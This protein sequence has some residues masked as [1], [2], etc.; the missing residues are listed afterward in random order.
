MLEKLLSSNS[1]VSKFLDSLNGKEHVTVY[2]LDLDARMLIL[3]ESD[4]RFLYITH[5]ITSCNKVAELCKKVGYNTGVLLPFDYNFSTF[6]NKICTSNL[7][8]LLSF[9]QG[10][11][12]CIIMPA[13][14]LFNKYPNLANNILRLEVGNSYNREELIDSLLSNGYMRVDGISDV[15]DFCIKGEILDI[16]VEQ[17]KCAR[18]TFFDDEIEKIYYYDKDTFAT[19]NS[20]DT[21]IVSN[22]SFSS[23][24][25]CDI[26]SLLK[27]LAQLADKIDD[28]GQI[29]EYEKLVSNINLLQVSKTKDITYLYPYNKK[30]CNS[31]FDILPKDTVICFDD[32]KQTFDTLVASEKEMLLD[33]KENIKLALA[34]PKHQKA[35]W[36]IDELKNKWQGYL[37][38]AFGIITS[39]NKLFDSTKVF[40]IKT[41]KIISYINNRKALGIDAKRYIDSGYTVII[42]AGSKEY[43]KRVC[44]EISRERIDCDMV[45]NASLISSNKVNVLSK[46]LP[47]SIML[48]VDKIIVIGTNMLLADKKSTIQNDEIIV[49]LPKIGDYVVHE[50]YGIGKYIDSVVLEYNNASREYFV[51]EYKGGD[52]LYLPCEYMDKISKY[53]GD[54]PKE[55]K[56]GSGDFLKAKESVKRSLKELAFD[57]KELY[58]KRLDSRGIVVPRDSDIENEISKT[59]E[60]TTTPDQENAIVDVYNDLA[61]GKIMDR[62][63][64]GD[65]GYGKTEV[66]IRA[67]YKMVLA[68][69]QVMFL[70]PT[71]ILSM[72]H[73]NTCNARLKEYGITVGVLNRFVSDQKR[74]EIIR[75]FLDGKI[76]VLCGTH[77]LLSKDVVAHKL[78][79]LVLDEEQKFGV[80]DKEKIKNIRSNIHV[81]TLSATPI[82]RTLNMSLVGIRDISIINTPPT[83]RLNV[84]TNVVGYSDELLKNAIHRELARG[85]QVLIVNNS[86][87]KIYAFAQKVKGLIGDDSVT[88]GVAHGQMEEHELS[89]EIFKLYNG[90]TRVLVATTLIE[91]G[92][93]LASANTLFVI[94]SDKLGLAQLYQLKGRV[95][96]S[97]VQA[98]SY[99]TYDDSVTLN[100]VAYKRLESI[101]EYSDL[102]SGYK[103]A[104]RDLEIRGAGNIFGAEQSGH[105][106]KVGYNMYI[107]L[108]RECIDEMKGV[109]HKNSDCEVQTNIDAYLPTYYVSGKS[110]RIYWY[111]QIAKVD[112]D[113]MY[114]Q[115]LKNMK[116]KIGSLCPEAENLVKIAYLKNIASKLDIKKVIINSNTCKLEFC[117]NESMAK[118]YEKMSDKD[119]V[120][121][122]VTTSPCIVFVSHVDNLSK[123]DNILSNVLEVYKGAKK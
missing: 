51:I 81:L 32:Y 114:D 48:D 40:N 47:L 17:G 46:Y 76:D 36:T 105:M 21:L 83:N 90:D 122:D 43:A 20:V 50:T 72:Q 28:R 118:F 70:C 34:T 75:D 54:S 8:T 24:N 87:A 55:S 86:V 3:R 10:Q 78:G 60:Y 33:I 80:G 121:L 61:S 100:E 45:S 119:I 102:G 14:A 91:N 93:D 49:E 9:S 16:C 4:K 64:C 6:S 31:I 19:L 42:Y 69:Y 2:G 112:S 38:V 98:Y 106:A 22:N 94:D 25:D 12:D 41:S 63:V 109:Y 89:R 27:D 99:F 123:I 57:L 113:K 59:F 110:E 67:I 116:E 29:D 56:L 30:I 103:I 115:M 95:G 77:S 1:L 53:I 108:L 88:V 44:D 96:R 111:T 7:S 82:P 104:M 68:G 58:A 85:G 92:V 52:K 5:D 35:I 39:N 117:D 65:V 18:V 107:T 23:I 71:T 26:D 84:I 74:K 13:D 97:N 101:L 79:L 73:Y 120:S 62:L 15:G 66:A 37:L 11:L